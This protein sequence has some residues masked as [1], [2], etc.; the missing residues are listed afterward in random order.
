MPRKVE[1]IVGQK[2]GRLTVIEN[3]NVNSHGSTL[4][5]CLCDC[6][7]EKI[8]PKSYLKSGHT[9]SCGCLQTERHT[10]HS[11]SQTRLYN[12]FCG[13]KKRCYN[14]ASKFYPYYGGKGV[15]ICDEWLNDFNCFFDWAMANGYDDELS[16]DR[17]DVD[18]NYEP[19]NCRW[20]TR[21]EQSNN[22]TK[23]IYIVYKG[24]TQTLSQW[25]RET[26][27]PMTTLN[28]RYKQK[29]DEED[30]FYKGDLRCKKNKATPP[31]A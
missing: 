14:K 4:H 30:L 2:F 17:I 10:T 12:I 3:L 25:S 21:Q 13:M 11:K 28:R 20:A 24:T 7:N 16:I 8:V 19:L 15:T 18:G 27:I 31:K 26:K 23:N 1:N 9:Q 29:K 6:G 5:R 22:T